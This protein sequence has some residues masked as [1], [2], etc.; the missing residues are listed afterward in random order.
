MKE[1]RTTQQN[2]E[3]WKD[4][5][6]YKG[7][8]KA[9]NFGRIKSLKRKYRLNDKIL[10]PVIKDIGYIQYILSKDNKQELF[11]GHRLIAKCF[12]PNPKNKP[13]INHKDGNGFNNRIDNLEWC[14]ASENG[15]HAYRILGNKAW[16]KGHTGKDTPTAKPV[17]QRYINGI[18]VKIWDCA[19]DA[20]RDG[21]F[22]SSCISRCCQKKSKYHKHYI[23]EY[24][25]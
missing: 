2:R 18:I 1:Q 17:I 11:L 14:T 22:E 16:H 15:L 9:S 4:I 8:Y 25:N 19:S 21:G 24:A 5:I 10:K 20:V 13:Q 7:L 12:I 6:G 23:W 3:I